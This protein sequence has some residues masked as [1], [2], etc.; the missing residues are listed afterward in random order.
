MANTTAPPNNRQIQAIKSILGHI[1]KLGNYKFSIRL[2]DGSMVPLGENVDSQYYVSIASPGI[3]G[4][5]LRKPTAENLLRQYATGHID[6]HGG[7]L[8]DFGKTLNQDQSSRKKFRSLKKSFIL[9]NALPFLTAFPQKT[10]LQH[11]FE[12][13]E[14]GR[15]ESKRDNKDYIQFHYDVSNEFYQLFLDPE[16]QYSCA[17]YQ[18]WNDSLEQAQINKLEMICRKLRL[19]PGDKMLDIGCG[20]GGLIC[21][22]AQHY[23][24]TAVGITL[25]QKQL[26]FAQAK[27]IRLGL[28]DRVSAHLCDYNDHEGSYDKISSVGMYEHIGLENIPKYFKKINSLMRDRGILLNHAISS[29]AKSS[30]KKAKKIR[31]ERR[32]LLKYIFPGS[33]LDSIGNTVSA[34]ELGGFEV[35]DV[36]TWR[37][38]YGRTCSL[39]CKRLSVNREKA[40]EL[41]GA[42]RY[43]LWVAYLAGVAFG[44]NAGGMRINQVVATKHASKGPSGMPPTRSDLYQ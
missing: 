33:E 32:L 5:L 34:M 10:D 36:E 37:E 27:I 39:W 20:W 17:Y 30:K 6:F 28:S 26:E 31:P 3:I 38:H 35:H 2:W 14:V 22:A 8:I 43:R 29:R 41:V 19:Q 42:E 21:Y 16:M 15:D 7:D 24:V 23:G 4:S 11:K 1:A 13:D 40:I 18:D 25:S 44:F 12:Q 9:K